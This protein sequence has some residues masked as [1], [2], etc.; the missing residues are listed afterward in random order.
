V[1]RL[2]VQ[3]GVLIAEPYQIDPAFADLVNAGRYGSISAAFYRPDSPNNPVP[4]VWYL[5]HVGFLGAQ[6][7]ALKGL[8]PPSFAGGPDDAV[9]FAEPRKAPVTTPTIPPATDPA[10]DAERR[11]LDDDRRRFDAD[12]AQFAEQRRTA[13]VTE[14]AAFLDDLVKGGKLPS[15][16][17][18]QAAQ[19]AALLDADQTVQ[20]AEAGR[21][22]VKSPLQA[23]KDLLGALPPMVQFGEAAR[24]DPIAPTAGAGIAVPSGC[25]VDPMKLA[26][27]NRAVAFA[28]AN[29]CNYVTAVM[30]VG[31]GA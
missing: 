22:I 13:T 30:A 1:L 24:P 15:G 12:R 3:N 14:T 6:P 26:L 2:T 27:H 7:P 20:F 19:F 29:N 21:T 17:K 11:K 8:P 25:Q 16:L 9:T 23:F 4:G 28:A 5:R 31:K 10:L 18:D